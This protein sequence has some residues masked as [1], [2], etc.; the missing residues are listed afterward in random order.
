MKLVLDNM[1]LEFVGRGK[2]RYR[3]SKGTLSFG[4]ELLVIGPID[5]SIHSYTI[6]VWENGVPL[7]ATE[8]QE[9]L[10]D[11]QRMCSANGV[12]IEIQ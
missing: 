3:S 9:V 12:S 6:A 10:D 2:G 1:E 5:Y 8:K 7:S 4:C 11:I